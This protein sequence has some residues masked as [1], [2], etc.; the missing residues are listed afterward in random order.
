MNKAVCYL[1][2]RTA[3]K[4]F[5][6]YITNNGDVDLKKAKRIVTYIVAKLGMS[7]VIGKI[8]YPNVEYVRKPYSDETESKIDK[9]V[10]RLYKE[11]QKRAEKMI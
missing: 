7:S 10:S 1:A 2:G 5:K 11:C 9:E 3:E 4:R 8:G 6:G